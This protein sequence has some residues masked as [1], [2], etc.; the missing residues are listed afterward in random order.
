MTTQR[1]EVE[2][3]NCGICRMPFN[4]YCPEC[5]EQVFKF[6]YCPLGMYLNMD[7]NNAPVIWK[8]SRIEAW[9][10]WEERG[11]GGGAGGL[12]RAEVPY[13]V[14]HNLH[15]TAVDLWGF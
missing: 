14:T 5:P 11:G 13:F 10:L 4:T 6:K 2:Y 8:P 12:C 3:D 9:A 1:E 15:D 7:R